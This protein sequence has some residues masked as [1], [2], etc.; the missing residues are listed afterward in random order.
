MSGE[1]V[2]Y[3]EAGN[4]M[5][6]ALRRARGAGLSPT[7]RNVLDAVLALTV[8]YSKLEDEI[9]PATIAEEAGCSL[10]QAR[11]SLRKLDDLG[12]VVYVPGLGRGR[13]SVVGLPVEGADQAAKREPARA[14][15]SAEKS[16]QPDSP[17]SAT[18]KGDRKAPKKGTATRAR[19]LARSLPG[20][21]RTEKKELQPQQSGERLT[22]VEGGGGQTER[23]SEV[24][25]VFNEEAETDYRSAGV[26]AK[27]EA[28]LVE[29][30]DVGLERHREAIRGT[31][32]AKWWKGNPGPELV[33]GTEAAFEHA[34]NLR[35]R[36][37][38]DVYDDLDAY[39]RA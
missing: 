7:D 31:L 11:R 35:P 25:R 36:D 26:L 18:V 6:E 28:R 38:P 3:R 33:Y 30:P 24:L 17:L 13:T 20:P 19:T 1:R 2:A 37:D 9:S 21:R 23:A 15:L 22:L 8:S 39:T 12:I 16:G 29:R 4:A 5:R 34:L 32:K 14:P 10:R 27:I